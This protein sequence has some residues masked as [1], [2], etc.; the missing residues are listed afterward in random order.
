MTKVL[1]MILLICS[2]ACPASALELEAPGVPESAADLFPK[3]HDSLEEG[4][5]E[6]LKAA[7]ASSLPD[8]SS[9][10]RISV[11][12][13]TIAFL[14]ELLQP[15]ASGNLQAWNLAGIGGT[16]ALLFSNSQA[17]ILLAVDTI[18]ELTQYGMLLLPVMTA[19]LAAQ[20][21]VSASAALYTGT[22]VFSALLGRLIHS[23]LVPLIY[24]FLG[25]GLLSGVTGENLLKRIQDLVKSGTAWLLKT[26]L[27]LFTTYMSITGAVS[28]TTDAAALKAAKVTISTVVPVVGGILSDASESVLVSAGILKNSAGI[29]GIFAVLALFLAPFLQ[30]AIHYLMMKATAAACSIL[31]SKGVTAVMDDFS[32]AMGLL[33]GMTGAVCLLILISTVCFL[34]GA[35]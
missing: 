9:G 24:L 20:G 21:G 17:M 19:G 15:L 5:P 22:A 30:I 3:H 18:R 32:W 2:L 25:L 31:G 23:V 27:I 11:S 26:T 35:A 28:G 12:I 34:K 14:L 10:I 33:L 16:A 1:M 7:I 29:Y 6:L 8:L 13:L 4:I